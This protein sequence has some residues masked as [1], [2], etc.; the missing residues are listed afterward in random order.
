[1]IFQYPSYSVHANYTH[2]IGPI[3]EE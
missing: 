1:L 2:V 3:D